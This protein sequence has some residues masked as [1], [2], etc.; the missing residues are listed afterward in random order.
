[1]PLI[2][3]NNAIELLNPY[4]K[5]IRECIIGAF[6]DYSKYPDW[7]RIDHDQ[8]T[9]ANIINNHMVQRATKAFID[10]KKI[11]ILPGRRQILF[12]FEQKISLR[13]KKLDGGLMPQNISTKQVKKLNGQVEISGI[14]AAHHLVAGYTLNTDLTEIDGVYMVCPNNNRVYWASK[15]ENEKT[16]SIVHD[17]FENKETNEYGSDFERKENSTDIEKIKDGTENKS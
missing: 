17:L 9:K 16:V 3:E 8:T 6:D 1:M 7:T 11:K 5:S 2:S 14:E 13:L 15:L 10:D 4:L 12:I